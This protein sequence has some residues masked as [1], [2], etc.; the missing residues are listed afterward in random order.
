M[1][2]I[3][4]VLILGSTG[5]IGLN[6]LSVISE[7]SEFFK[8]KT[9]VAKSNLAQLAQQAI[10]HNVENVVIADE[11]KYYDLKLLLSHTKINIYAG[12]EAIKELMHLK[13]D[14]TIAGIVGI[15]CLEPIID[16]IPNTKILGI[17]NKESLVCAGEII[18]KLA[19]Q[20]NTQIIPLDS[21]HNAIFQVL[22]P[23]NRDKLDK[24]TLTASGGP[25]INKT[26]GEMKY[27]TPKEAIKHPNWSMGAKISVDSATL[28]NKGLE[29]IEAAQL[30]ALSHEDIDVIIHPESIIHGI[31]SYKDGSNLAQCSTPDI[32]VPISLALSYP[33]RTAFNYRILNLSHIKQLNFFDPDYNR[34]PLLK[35]AQ[36]AMKEG[37]AAR[38]ILNS[39]NEIAV[40]LFLQNHIEFLDIANIVADLL[41]KVESIKINSIADIL[42]L[43]NL[44]S[45]KTYS[46]LNIPQY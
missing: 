46:L 10:N 29:I 33:K 1:N 22:E 2:Y 45:T 31:I 7:H 19:T 39:A 36:Q 43:S 14:I 9:L 32:R 30:F 12:K 5:S 25:F 3:K 6:T 41:E 8:I 40:E 18:L 26:I 38:I 20:H 17:A 42:Y 28:M 35:L 27:V 21:E 23:H 11:T 34:F 24:I 44:T 37:Q 13:Y 15:A 4:E 16:V